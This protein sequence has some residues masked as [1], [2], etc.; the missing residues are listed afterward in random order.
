MHHVTTYTR[1]PIRSGF[2]QADD[3]ALGKD[4]FL[5]WVSSDGQ[6]NEKIISWVRASFDPG[7]STS[8][9]VYEGERQSQ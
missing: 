9:S 6:L 2:G 4:M 5:A 8:G 7:V 3:S 1:E